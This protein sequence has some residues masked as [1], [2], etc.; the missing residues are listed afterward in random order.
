MN[1]SDEIK[2]RIDIVDLVSDT[3]KLRR[4]G[5]N[6]SGFCP[7]HPNTRTPAF[8]VFPDSGTWRC[9]GACNE[10]GD[11]FRFVMKKEG[12][13]FKEALKLLARKAGVKLETDTPE[14]QKENERADQLAKLLEEVA[15]YYQSHLL[16]SAEG[17]RAFQYLLEKRGISR[18]TIEKFGL[19]FSPSGWDLTLN[20][21]IAKGYKIDDLEQAGLIVKRDEGGFYDRFRGRIMFPVRDAG[22]RLTGF[23]ARVLNPDEVPKFI[24]SPQTLLFDKSRLLYGLDE[25]R[26]AVREIDQ[27]VIVEGYLDVLALHQAGFANTVSPMGTALTETQMRQLKRFTRR[28]VMALDPDAAG[29]KA[30]LRGLEIARDALDH[31]TDLVFDARGL[32]HHESRLQADLRVCT[33][34]SGMDPDDIVRKDPEQWKQILSSAKP[35]ITHVMITLSQGRDLADPKT[36]SEIA[37]Q[38]LPL[39]NDVPDSVERD[40]YLQQLARMLRVEVSAFQG[41]MA[42]KRTPGNLKK[43]TESEK[44]PAG[45]QIVDS[46]VLRAKNNTTE[47]YCLKLL[48]PRPEIQYRINRLLNAADLKEF[49]ENDFS[50]AKHQLFARLIFQSLEQE[51]KDPAQFVEENHLPEL[52]EL[53]D[54]LKTVTGKQGESQPRMSEQKQVEEVIRSLLILRRDRIQSEIN[55]LQLMLK[56]ALQEMDVDTPLFQQQIGDLILMRGKLDRALADPMQQSKTVHV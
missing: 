27:A 50:D 46:T 20:H 15:I 4:S 22:G 33:L 25:A 3:V 56:E 53:F 23:G 31:T 12:V 34:P 49:S 17:K 41:L 48:L 28:I 45:I 24:N 44:T 1:V 7:F 43:R 6:Y 40:A 32:L 52:D 55:Q 5:K 11:I 51:G 38:V 19:G 10:G 14:K 2:S 9:F 42:K 18:E 26:K 13:D 16:Q 8:V 21:F 39:I 47:K 36:M 35:I 37:S 54:E 29:I 30:T